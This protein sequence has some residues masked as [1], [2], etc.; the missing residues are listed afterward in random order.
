MDKNNVIELL[1]LI[2]KD[3]YCE[4]KE[5]GTECLITVS[6]LFEIIDRYI[7]ELEITP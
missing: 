3:S 5:I 1:K 4:G 7:S 6:R 2:K